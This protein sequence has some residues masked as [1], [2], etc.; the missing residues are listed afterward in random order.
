MPSEIGR[1]IK[2]GIGFALGVAF[3]L[4]LFLF[5]FSMCAGHIHRRMMERMEEM[6][7]GGNTLPL[8]PVM[9]RLP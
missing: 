1:G 5:S 2:F 9:S 7:P 3:I 6:M 4:T 8:R